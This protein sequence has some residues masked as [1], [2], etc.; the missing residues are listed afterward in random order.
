MIFFLMYDM[1]GDVVYVVDGMRYDLNI[2]NK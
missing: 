1:M 2:N